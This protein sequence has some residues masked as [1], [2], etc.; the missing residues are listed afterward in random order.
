MYNRHD[1]VY[2]DGEVVCSVLF[3]M[4]MNLVAN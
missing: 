2:I 3:Y 4:Y 1:E